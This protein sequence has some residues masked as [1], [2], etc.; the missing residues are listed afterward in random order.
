M[1]P[2][3]LQ[4]GTQIIYVP[5]HADGVSHSDCEIGFVTSM[6]EEGAFCRYWSKHNPGHLRTT[7][8]SEMT[9]FKNL[10]VMNTYPQIE[11]D[12]LLHVI[13]KGE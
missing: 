10:V 7:A 5:D 11:I 9:Q 13:E 8:N 1:K 6:T 3:N 4:K 12:A 2:Q